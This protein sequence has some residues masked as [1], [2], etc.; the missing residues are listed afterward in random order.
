MMVGNTNTLLS[1][2]HVSMYKLTRGCTQH[3]YSITALG[4][5]STDSA[6]A[7][8]RWIMYEFYIATVPQDPPD[9]QYRSAPF[10]HHLASSHYA[11]LSCVSH[12]TRLAVAAWAAPPLWPWRGLESSHTVSPP[13]PDGHR[14]PLSP[15][16]SANSEQS[17]CGSVAAPDMSGSESPAPRW[18]VEA[19]AFQRG[20]QCQRETPEPQRGGQSWADP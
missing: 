20:E 8:Q 19:E 18:A 12:L 15:Q 13:F 1:P 14:A 7:W 2:Y 10:L 16:K 6:N 5:N 17:V 11:E 9:Q 3:P 4:V